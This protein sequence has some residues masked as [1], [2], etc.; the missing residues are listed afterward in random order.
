MVPTSQF[1]KKLAIVHSARKVGEPV[2]TNWLSSHNWHSS[3][4]LH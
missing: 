3:D 4:G 1:G 2:G